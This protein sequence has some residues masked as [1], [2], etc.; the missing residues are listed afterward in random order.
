MTLSERFVMS[1]PHRLAFEK[2]KKI[3]LKTQNT[4][5]I[6]GKSIDKSVK[7]PRPYSPVVDHIVPINKG[8]H[9]SAIDHATDRSQI[10]C[11]LFSQDKQM[12]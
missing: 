11:S 2:N 7:S 1:A 8:G 4:C 9:P 5:G 6:C 3:S 12:C 10:N